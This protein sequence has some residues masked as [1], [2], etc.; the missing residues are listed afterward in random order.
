MNWITL[1][2]YHMKSYCLKTATLGILFAL[3]LGS[4]SKS[5]EVNLSDENGSLIG[6]WVNP[7]YTGDTISWQKAPNLIEYAYGMSIEK[8]GV[9]IERKNAGWCGTPPISYADYKGSWKLENEVLILNGKYWGGNFT[10]SYKILSLSSEKM[11][12]KNLL[13]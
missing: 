13:Q 7:V 5:D 1:I 11:V 10:T 6:H 2:T 3:A 4:C 12:V 8:T 9:L